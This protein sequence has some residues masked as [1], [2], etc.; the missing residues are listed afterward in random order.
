ML[1]MISA[2]APS[3]VADEPEARRRRPQGGNEAR[4]QR[5]SEGPRARRKLEELPSREGL[6]GNMPSG[7]QAEASPC[8]LLEASGGALG[9]WVIPDCRDPPMFAS[10][11]DPLRRI[12][13]SRLSQHSG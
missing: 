7:I 2:I 4:A 12:W 11:G 5:R 13:S 10:G 9:E 1:I 3:I 8:L 6:L